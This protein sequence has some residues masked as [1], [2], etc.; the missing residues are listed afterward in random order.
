VE[1]WRD[2]AIVAIF[3][4]MIDFAEAPLTALRTPPRWWSDT[5]HCQWV[6]E[7]DPELFA[8]SLTELK[9][10]IAEEMK[11]MYGL[12]LQLPNCKCMLPP[13]IVT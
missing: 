10:K 5:P 8:A 2:G 11:L 12:Q 13:D 3:Q 1:R 6:N 4:R 7:Y 9:N